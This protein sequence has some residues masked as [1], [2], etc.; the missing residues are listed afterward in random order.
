MKISFDHFVDNTYLHFLDHS[1]GHSLKLRVST[2]LS[3]ILLQ[4]VGEELIAK[5]EDVKGESILIYSKEII[6]RKLLQRKTISVEWNEISELPPGRVYLV[7]FRDLRKRRMR[8]G[9][10]QV[11]CFPR[12]PH[13]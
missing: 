12:F 4:R 8:T 5:L 6:P 13:F 3:T 7:D 11:L 2:I 10:E 1:V 9:S